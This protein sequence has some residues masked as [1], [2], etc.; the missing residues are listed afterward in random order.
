M[1]MRLVIL[2]GHSVVA[3][4]HETDD[5]ARTR[6]ARMES[7]RDSLIEYTDPRVRALFKKIDAA[8]QETDALNTV[9]VS[10]GRHIVPDIMADSLVGSLGPR[11]EEPGT[12][13]QHSR[14]RATLRIKCAGLLGIPLVEVA[15]VIAQLRRNRHFR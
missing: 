11:R 10:S 12:R 3:F 8:R 2:N 4:S 9:L 15:D 13:N 5:Q 14:E 1:R 7:H 6:Y